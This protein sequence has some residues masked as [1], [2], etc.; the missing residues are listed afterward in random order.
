MQRSLSSFFAP[1]SSSGGSSFIQKL[2]GYKYL[3]FEHKARWLLAEHIV[4]KTRKKFNL[5]ELQL[6]S[7]S[8]LEWNIKTGWLKTASIQRR[9]P[10]LWVTHLL[11]EATQNEAT[12]W[13]SSVRMCELFTQR[14][15]VF[16]DSNERNWDDFS[17]Q[18]L[19]TIQGCLKTRGWFAS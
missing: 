10:F 16:F 1:Q 2:D 14:C 4:Q 12:K 15:L 8:K 18:T 5:V 11:V 13:Y 6:I 9:D 7:A 17:W 3:I 19:K